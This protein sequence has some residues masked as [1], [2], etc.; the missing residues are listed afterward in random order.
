MGHLVSSP[1]LY[2]DY[3]CTIHIADNDVF[4][5][6]T[7]HIEITAI[8]FANSFFNTQVLFD[9]FHPM[10]IWLSYS[11]TL[12]QVLGFISSCAISSCLHLVSTRVCRDKQTHEGGNIGSHSL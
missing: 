7:K 5:E 3:Q 9:P 6:H 1:T 8:L 10:V 11:P 12:F 4:R 2:C